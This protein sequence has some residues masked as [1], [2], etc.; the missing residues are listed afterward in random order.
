M[1]YEDSDIERNGM[2]IIPT[3]EDCPTITRRVKVEDEED[4]TKGITVA[5][6]PDTIPEDINIYSS[7]HYM[8]PSSQNKARK[9]FQ[10]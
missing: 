2:I 4:L 1:M 9:R 3:D 6:I 7:N 10:T 5:T 8:Q